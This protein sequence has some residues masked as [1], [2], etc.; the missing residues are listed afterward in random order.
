MLA[1]VV[2][3]EADAGLVYRTDAVAAGD[4]V[5]EVP[6]PEADATAYA[7]RLTLATRNTADF[8]AFPIA[9]VNP[10]A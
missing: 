3:G 4:D 7:H 6:F 2:Q 1:R 10:W 9:V 5:T 8:L